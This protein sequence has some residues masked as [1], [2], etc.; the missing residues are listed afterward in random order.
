MFQTIIP[1]ILSIMDELALNEYGRKVILYLVAWRNSSYFHPQVIELL[2]SGDL[3]KEW[4][5]YI[6][7]ID[8]YISAWPLFKFESFKC[9]NSVCLFI[10]KFLL[11]KFI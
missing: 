6:L 10:T 2:K 5:Y 3:I 11:L 1:E 4:Y 8:Q 9:V 7:N